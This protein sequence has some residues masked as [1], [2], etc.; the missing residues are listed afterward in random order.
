MTQYILK[1]EVQ[2]D[3]FSPRAAESMTGLALVRKNEPGE[4]GSIGRFKGQPIPYGAAAVEV[5][6]DLS[7]DAKWKL[8][9]ITMAMHIE[10]LRECGAESI[11]LDLGCFHEGQCNLAFSS[12]QLSQVAALGIPFTIS[13]YEVGEGE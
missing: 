4:I 13:C 2:G 8:L 9:L 7:W 1:C 10:A 11:V 12:E 6:D 5:P 3:R